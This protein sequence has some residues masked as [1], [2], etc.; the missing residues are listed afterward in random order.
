MK[1]WKYRVRG[2]AQGILMEKIE[3]WGDEGWEVFQIDGN[4]GSWKV[5]MKREKQ[6]DEE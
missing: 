2:A 5:Y 4:G 3:K 1:R 6:E